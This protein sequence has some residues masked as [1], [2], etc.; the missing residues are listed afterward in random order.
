MELKDK[1]VLLT[2]AASGIGRAL[3]VQLQKAGAKLA[4]C[5]VRADMLEEVTQNL[6]EEQYFS[7][8]L[9][10]TDES[11]VNTFIDAIINKFGHIDVLINNA[12]VALGRFF[13]EEVE[14]KDLDWLMDINLKAPLLITQKLLPNLKSRPEAY[15]VLLSSV[16]GLAGIKQQTPY[17]VSKFAIRGLGESLRMELLDTNVKVLNVHPAGVKTN[18]VNFSRMKAADQV[19]M[20]K[21]FN[22]KLAK[23]GAEAAAK[24]IVNSIL[25]DKNRLLI[26]SDARVIDTLTRLFPASYSKIF[27]RFFKQ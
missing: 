21:I 23:I 2:G 3:V 8:V 24:Q 9:D 25:K 11:A 18:I 7:S 27:Y 5:D 19:K 4:I 14:R 6:P 20:P 16:F 1:V 26:G 10:V 22:E 13:L 15:I 12:G 17:C